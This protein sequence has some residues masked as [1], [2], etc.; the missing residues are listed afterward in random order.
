MNIPW[1]FFLLKGPKL[2]SW[3]SDRGRVVGGRA[4]FGRH[5]RSRVC[6]KGEGTL[7]SRV[8]GASPREGRRERGRE[9]PGSCAAASDTSLHL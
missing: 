2:R 6:V 3:K 8:L 1:F 7:G 5:L 9:E 4:E